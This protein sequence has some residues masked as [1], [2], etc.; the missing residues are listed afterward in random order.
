M[1]KCNTFAMNDSRVEA[2][3][4]NSRDQSNFTEDSIDV[5][6]PEAWRLR[7]ALH[8]RK[9]RN[10]MAIG[11]RGALE[12]DSPPLM[13]G[14]VMPNKKALLWWGAFRKRI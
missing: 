6:F 9:D 7:V 10:D 8:R 1:L 4:V 14:M 11:N 13:E 3:F 2:L 5:L 12:I